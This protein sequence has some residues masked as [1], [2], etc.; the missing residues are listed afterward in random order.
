MAGLTA[1]SSRTP[2]KT[3]IA[4]DFGAASKTY[5][6]AAR[7]QRYM[8][9]V[10][11]DQLLEQGCLPEAGAGC[12]VLDL[13][14]GTGWFTGQL[15]EMVGG[16]E[17]S[18]TGADLSPGMLDYARAAG[19]PGTHWL[20]A[21]AESLPL[22]DNSLDLVFSNLMIQ[23]CSDSSGVLAECRRVLRP[24]GR[25][26]ISTLLDGTLDE[27]RIAWYRADPEHEHVNRF[28]SEAAFR[29]QALEVLPEP[30]IS[31]ESITLDYPSPLALLAELKAIGAGFK[32]SSRRRHATAPGRLRAMCHHY[33]KG[34]DGQVYATYKA[35]WLTCRLPY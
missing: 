7:L 20:V 14:C 21:D 30:R 15:A 24:G 2:A 3:A 8:G 27:L 19:A 33:P 34:S 25:L 23:W 26:F 9:Q 13:G 10:M 35:A 5:N 17:S 1:A 32:G 4:R 6:P 16:P 12:Q 22:E 31:T 18:V 29:S 28:E 11:V